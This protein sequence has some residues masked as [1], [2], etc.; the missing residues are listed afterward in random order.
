MRAGA[1]VRPSRRLGSNEMDANVMQPDRLRLCLVIIGWS[2]AGLSRRLNAHPDVARHWAHGRKN[3]PH[4]A[5]VWLESLAAAFAE[6]DAPD[7]PWK[8][9]WSNMTGEDL[10]TVLYE[11]SWSKKELAHRLNCT[12]GAVRHMVAGRRPIGQDVA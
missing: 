11:L 3:I 12:L 5:G 7:Q 6:F 4:V 9:P 2:Q 1:R 8:Q 10:A